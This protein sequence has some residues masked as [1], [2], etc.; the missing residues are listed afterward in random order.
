MEGNS[1]NVFTRSRGRDRAAR[2]RSCRSDDP[3][4]A[5]RGAQL[6]AGE[7]RQGP[8]R[9]PGGGVA[10][11]EA[12][13]H[14]RLHPAQLYSSDGRP[15]SGEGDFSRGRGRNRSVRIFGRTSRGVER[16]RNVSQSA[17][18]L[19]CNGT[20]NRSRSLCKKIFKAG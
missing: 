10:N 18:V 13:R 7:S 4:S 12:D 14:V 2:E 9:E 1:W 15:T 8:Q 3:L 20:P 5:S 11:G 19:T 16:N 6:D 17:T